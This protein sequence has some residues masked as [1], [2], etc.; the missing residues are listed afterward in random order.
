EAPGGLAAVES[1]GGH[2]VVAV[3]HPDADVVAALL[4]V[5]VA[6]GDG[7][8]A[9]TQVGHVQAGLLH[10][11]AVAPVDPH[12]VMARVVGRA[13]LVGEGVGVGVYAPDREGLA[14][15]RA[16]AVVPEGAVLR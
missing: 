14:R 8:G 12:R 16:A 15:A 5:G 9:V 10:G 11:A 4:G 6:G 13:V 7:I 3:V 1:V 2:E